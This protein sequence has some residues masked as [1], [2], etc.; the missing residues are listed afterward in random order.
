VVIV[1]GVEK[2]KSE[3]NAGKIFTLSKKSIHTFF[4]FW[5]YGYGEAGYVF[6]ISSGLF[7]GR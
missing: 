7:T 3:K 5:G 1:I 2:C 4:L 6:R